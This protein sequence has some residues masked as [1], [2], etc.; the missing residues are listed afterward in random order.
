[1]LDL[2]FG[3]TAHG[4]IRVY[5]QKGSPIPEGWAFDPDGHSTTDAV[6]AMKGL[7][8]PIGQHKGVGLGMAIGMLSSF[9]SGVASADGI[10][11]AAATVDGIIACA[12]KLG[13]D[14]APLTMK[15]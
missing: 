6:A 10:M 13:L 12:E 5:H 1:V 2:A 7:I 3:A 9:L 11:L 4:K 14:P 8:Q 15:S